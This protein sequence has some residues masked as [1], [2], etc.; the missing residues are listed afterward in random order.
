MMV[1]AVLLPFVTAPKQLFQNGNSAKFVFYFVPVIKQSVMRGAVSVGA[2]LCFFFW[3]VR[4]NEKMFS[5]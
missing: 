3:H 5:I 1:L 4:K 2:L